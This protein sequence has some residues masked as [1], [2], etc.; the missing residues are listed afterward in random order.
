MSNFASRLRFSTHPINHV[1]CH[2]YTHKDPIA[3]LHQSVDR[4]AW[5]GSS[6]A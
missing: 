5:V 3:V 1:S 2:L 6:W 4:I